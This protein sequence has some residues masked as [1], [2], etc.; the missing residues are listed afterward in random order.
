VNPFD[1][2]AD[3]Q[4]HAIW[5]RLVRVDCEAF[6][7]GDWSMVES[8]F[9]ADVFE[10]IRCDGSADPTRWQIAFPDLASY[11]DSWLAASQQFVARR[12][13]EGITPRD[14]IFART[15]L[16]TIEIIGDRALCWK[17]FYGRIPLQDGSALADTRQSLFRLHRRPESAWGWQ[18]VGFLGN[19]PLASEPPA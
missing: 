12:F 5:D 3:P 10:G 7:A 1:A 2:T 9:D 19:L 14:A 11:R 6:V 18:V 13:A 8:D 17:Q 16:T 15:H 4:R